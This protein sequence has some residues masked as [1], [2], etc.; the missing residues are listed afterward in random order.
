MSRALLAAAAAFLPLCAV[1]EEAPG[2]AF[3]SATLSTQSYGDWTGAYAGLGV[4]FGQIDDDPDDT[5]VRVITLHGG[6]LQDLGNFVLGAE[7]ETGRL[8]DDEDIL[9]Q[10]RVTRIKGV[11]GYDAGRFMPYVT[12]GVGYM[13]LDFDPGIGTVTFEDNVRVLGLGTTFAA[14][15]QMRVG[16]EYLQD[17]A[18]DFDNL[19]TEID[20]R[21]L[22]VRGSFA[23]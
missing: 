22:S 19:G 12:A 4:A 21:T 8:T 5:D 3:P 10:G 15:D 20:M 23:F 1:A 18:G 6:Y 9:E 11:A 16:V 14:T 2:L 7:I 17:Y 13:A